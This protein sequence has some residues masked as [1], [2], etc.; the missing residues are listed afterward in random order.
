[1]KKSSIIINTARGGIINE[2][3]LVYAIKNKVI[4]GAGID[5][6]TEEP[7]K[8]NHVYYQIIEKSNF[9]WTPHT[10]WASNETLQRAI[11]QLISN[12]NSFYGGRKKNLV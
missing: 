3:D 5:V 4:A 12:I 2:R 9:L 6:T 10:A 7:P 11:N 1:M 8:I